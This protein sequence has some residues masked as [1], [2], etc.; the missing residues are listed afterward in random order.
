MEALLHTP[1]TSVP[2]SFSMGLKHLPPFTEKCSRAKVAAQKQAQTCFVT[3]AV[4]GPQRRCC[5][6]KQLYGE[7][8]KNTLQENE[9]KLV[10]NTFSRALSKTY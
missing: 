6:L 9:I 4:S 7:N 2:K 10:T 8:Q 5:H 3:G 1:N